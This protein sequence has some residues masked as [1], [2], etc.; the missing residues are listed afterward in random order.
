MPSPTAVD[1]KPT[2]GANGTAVGPTLAINHTDDDPTGQRRELRQEGAA[3]AAAGS[4]VRSIG[5][6]R[7]E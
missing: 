4:V 2:P 7:S 1:V 5:S 6:S 3:V